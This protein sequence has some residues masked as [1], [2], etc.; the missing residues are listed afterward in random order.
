MRAVVGPYVVVG[1]FNA[2]PSVDPLAIIQRR[3]IIAFSPARIAFDL[4]GEL[5]EDAH[6]ALLLIQAKIGV[7]ESASDEDMHLAKTVDV[8]V[9]LDPRAK[10]LTG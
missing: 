4:A 9:K 6:D 3:R 7:L 1:Y 10:D 2:A 8:Q 5:T